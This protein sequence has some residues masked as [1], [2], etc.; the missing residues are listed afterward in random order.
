MIRDV[1]VLFWVQ[2]TLVAL[3][4]GV[5]QGFTGFG[6]A[7][8]FTPVFALLVGR[9]QEVIVLSLVIGT[10]LSLGV[11]VETRCAL[12]VRRTWP[13]IISAMLAAPLG[14][15]L[16]AKIDTHALKVLI[17]ICATGTAVLW[18]IRQ[19][20][21]LRWE[22]GTLAQIFREAAEWTVRQGRE[23]NAAVARV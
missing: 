2:A 18:M 11:L 1:T 16:L 7:V 21:P 19:P 13:L 20:A 10:V 14:V 23:A 6:F 22:R 17:G 8:I 5:G 15:W 9:P 3:V 12:D 4:A